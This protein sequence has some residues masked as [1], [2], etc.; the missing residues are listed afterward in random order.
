MRID[1][2]GGTQAWFDI[3]LG[4]F[5]NEHTG[6]FRAGESSIVYERYR[7]K[8]GPL[9]I[10]AAKGAVND[11]TPR[12]DIIGRDLNDADL[13]L[14]NLMSQLNVSLLR[15]DY[16]S[17]DSVL[18]DSVTHSHG[19]TLYFVDECEK[20]PRV[21]CTQ[22][23]EDYWVGRGSTRKT[24]ERRERKLLDGMGAEY[25]VLS[26]WEEVEPV[27]EEVYD[28]ECSGWKGRQGSGIKQNPKIKKFYSALIEYWARN[29]QLRL[30]VLRYENRI[31]AFQINVLYQGVLYMLKIG[32]LDD[33]SSLSPG[34]ALQTQILRWAFQQQ[35]I[36]VFDMLGGGG[37]AFATKM[38]WA[39]HAEQ[40]YTLLVFKRDFAGRLAW[41]RYV[42]APAVKRRLLKLAG[43]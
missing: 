13:F 24:W 32:Y 26:R 5:G 12:Y 41:F 40:L 22:S 37:E 1:D 2:I 42:V 9:L 30:C 18:L 19:K 20:S 6:V 3:W 8:I 14:G 7:D 29:R 4:A 36:K 38:K 16:L 15:F 17:R 34:Q 10:P 35:E 39:T 11:H 23:W 27:L 43:K 21:D 28:V 33:Y 31:I 25:L